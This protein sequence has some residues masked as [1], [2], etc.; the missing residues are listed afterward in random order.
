M[1]EARVSEMYDKL[2]VCESDGSVREARRGEWSGLGDWG[3]AGGGGY[4]MAQLPTSQAPP[5]PALPASTILQQ[6]PQPI[7]IPSPAFR[8]VVV[9]VVYY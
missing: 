4:I 7:P 2:W 9:V 1:Y 5:L 8:C 3:R 6:L